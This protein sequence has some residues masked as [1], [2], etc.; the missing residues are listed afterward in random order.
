MQQ[1]R[2]ISGLKK[3]VGNQIIPNTVECTVEDEVWYSDTSLS[4][5]KNV[6]LIT[7]R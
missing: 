5:G 3:N 4:V 6:R 1:T 7:S 2:L